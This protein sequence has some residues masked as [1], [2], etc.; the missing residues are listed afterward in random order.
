MHYKKSKEVLEKIKR[1]DRILI[2]CHRKPDPDSVGSATAMYQVLKQFKKEATL[3]CPDTIT[4]ITKFIPFSD[5]VKKVNFSKFTFSDYDLFIILD[6]GSWELVSG[7]NGFVIPNIDTI[8]I[9]HHKSGT[10]NADLS[11]V[12]PERTANTAILYD[13]FKDWKANVNKDTATSLMAGLVG[14][15]G[16]F[17]YPKVSAATFRTA[18]ELMK[19]GVDKDMIVREIYRSEPYNL[20]K[21]WGEVLKRMEHDEKY[22]FVYSA[23]PSRIYRNFGSPEIGRETS[24]DKFTQIV[25]GTD[26]GMVM[27]EQEKNRLSVSFRSRTGF[28]T[29]RI[30]SSLGG[31]GHAYSSGCQL[32]DIPFRKAVE[33]VI[34][35][36]REVIKDVNKK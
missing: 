6:S 20:L 35:T 5:K 33:K 31:G 30:A 19:K 16:A 13:I 2:N 28:D 26:F 25:D 22:G 8:L 32:K 24:A 12:D 9:D 15:T 29:S 3:I 10:I 17:Q 11:I 21:F 7:G 18:M 23:I 27:V 1:S 34:S 14:D 36:T 4:R